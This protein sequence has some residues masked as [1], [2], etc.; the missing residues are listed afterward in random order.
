MGHPSAEDQ[1]APKLH[2]LEKKNI[3]LQNSGDIKKNMLRFTD[4]KNEF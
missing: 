3:N 4:N 1:G 2:I